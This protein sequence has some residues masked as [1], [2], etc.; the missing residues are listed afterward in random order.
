MERV[1]D[2]LMGVLEVFDPKN[3]DWQVLE[4]NGKKELKATSFY[5]EAQI[6]TSRNLRAEMT[7][8]EL[9]G[10]Q[11][12]EALNALLTDANSYG[13]AKV[14][15][16]CLALSLVEKLPVEA[17]G[18]VA[19]VRS[20][21]DA[22]LKSAKDDYSAAKLSYGSDASHEY[23]RLSESLNALTAKVGHEAIKE[24][25]LIELRPAILD[26]LQA[27]G[28]KLS[29]DS[30][31]TSLNTQGF[32]GWVKKMDVG[33]EALLRCADDLVYLMD[34]NASSADNAP[35][36]PT[37][38]ATMSP[39]PTQPATSAPP[40]A[41]PDI[42][43]RIN[44]VNNNSPV[45]NNNQHGTKG[46][47]EVPAETGGHEI[48]A[49]PPPRDIVQWILPR[50]ILKGPAD[51]ERPAGYFDLPPFVNEEMA[52]SG[53]AAETEMPTPNDPSPILQVNPPEVKEVADEKHNEPVIVGNEKKPGRVDKRKATT[54]PGSTAGEAPGKYFRSCLKDINI[55]LR[56]PVSQGSGVVYSIDKACVRH[57]VTSTAIADP[58]NNQRVI[59]YDDYGKREE[60]EM[61]GFYVGPY[62]HAPYTEINHHGRG[63]ETGHL[64]INRPARK[65][66]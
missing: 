38:P 28:W 60:K 6:A 26:A 58:D 52:T 33:T 2:Y 35:E 61:V 9:S 40:P 15:D 54:T 7:R 31:A 19:A 18:E 21:M 51:N 22:Y 23:G 43:I 64:T 57:N 5:S 14:M 59:R 41:L 12:D 44:P 27:K 50:P 36:S 3:A 48:D 62:K 66:S 8:Q 56:R 42:H 55:G 30:V 65:A 17:S 4:R 10:N 45:F 53:S 63:A 37:S 1:N 47:S 29:S 24:Q 39:D 49:D 46:S 16:A 13:A 32:S 11:A 25:L 34:P 20:A